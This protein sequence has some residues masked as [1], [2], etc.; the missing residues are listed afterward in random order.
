MPTDRSGILSFVHIL[1]TKT[2]HRA[3]SYS[4]LKNQKSLSDERNC[5]V[6]FQDMYINRGQQSSQENPQSTTVYDFTENSD[7]LVRL[8]S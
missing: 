2:I 4:R 7:R 3:N 6:T 8:W 5:K 1:V